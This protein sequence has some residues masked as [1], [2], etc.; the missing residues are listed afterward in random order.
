MQ[1]SKRFRNWL[2]VARKLAAIRDAVTRIREVLPAEP[3]QF[4]ADR[5]SREVIALNLLVAIQECL[6]VA[7]HWL[8][9]EGS[10][11][12]ASYREVLLTLADHNVLDR[13]LALR[14]AS[15]AGLRNLIAH[16]YA[17][18][19]WERIHTVA[20]QGLD[21]LIRFCEIIATRIR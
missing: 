20:A 12:P 21:D 16:Q 17:V 1:P 19:D 9:D 7:T 8:A 4:L 5:T 14:L 13:A 15:A 6:S 2:L 18:L 3:E 11:V 10:S